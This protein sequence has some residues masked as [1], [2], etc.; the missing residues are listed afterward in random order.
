M[1]TYR[2]L[3]RNI[4]RNIRP[5]YNE[6]SIT[7]PGFVWRL[8]AFILAAI[9]AF[10]VP[11]FAL[12]ASA[13]LI[14][15]IP[16][17][18][19]FD[20]SRSNILKDKNLSVKPGDVGGHINSY[21]LHKTDDFSLTA[22]SKG[23]KLELFSQKDRDTMMSLRAFLDR[24]IPFG[25][26]GLGLMIFC[27]V[28]LFFMERNIHIRRSFNIGFCISLLSLGFF[29]FAIIYDPVRESVWK[30]HLGVTLGSTD[31]LPL[32]FGDGFFITCL[33]AGSAISIVILLSLASA[34]FAMTRNR[35]KMF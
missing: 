2:T 34:V 13:N 26:T 24:T 6:A 7:M 29:A 18:Y 28:I 25:V 27:F 19:S 23:K 33:I 35:E 31:K 12:S 30:D 4:S 16:D 17:V 9:F 21:M 3:K 5:Y 11:V 20:L 15:R 22:E 10:S 8:V 32:L 1:A 14:F